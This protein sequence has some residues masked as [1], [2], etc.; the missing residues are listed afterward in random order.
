MGEVIAPSK[1]SLT[2]ELSATF[3]AE[4]S[5]EGFTLS[6]DFDVFD[7]SIHPIHKKDSD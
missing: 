4:A 3:A 6:L 1:F 7:S 2:D 5:M